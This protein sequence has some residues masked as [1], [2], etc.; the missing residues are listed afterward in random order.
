MNV[1]KEISLRN[2]ISYCIQSNDVNT[3]TSRLMEFIR[4]EKM[5]LKNE[6]ALL[7]STLKM[8][9]K[10]IDDMKLNDRFGHTQTCLKEA[11][12]KAEI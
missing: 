4:D 7:L 1:Q 9:D 8:V 3:A 2:A 12:D 10:A 6:N 5:H 11:I